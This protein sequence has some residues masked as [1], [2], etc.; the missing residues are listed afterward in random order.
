[1][2]QSISKTPVDIDAASAIA[3][4]AFGADISVVDL[5]ELTEGWFNAAYVLTLDDGQRCVLKVAPPP[6][7]AVLTYERD[8]MTTEVAALGLVRDRTTVPVPLVLW[9][10]T[11]CRRLP[12]SLFVM[13]HCDGML[14]SELRPTL[15]VAQQE[16]VDGQLASYLRKLN[17]I[18]NPT[19]GLQSPLAPKFTRWSDA[20]LQMFDD[21]LAD[22]AAMN[23]EL[24]GG[25]GA[26]RTLAHDHVDVLDEIV[27]PRFVHWDLWDPNV[28]VDPDTLEVI[29]VIDFERAL[30]GDPL[31]EGQFL[32]KVD[33]PSFMEA[34]GVALVETAGARRRRLLYDLYLFVIM[35]VEVA[36]RHYPT[37]E[38]DRLAR[39]QLASTLDKLGPAHH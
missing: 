23:V 20:F 34:Y 9:S 31:M 30:W 6:H 38:I 7:V 32:T 29:G 17:A 15:D 12:S 18:T 8:I 3:R 27:E 13:E 24:P 10:D 22:G 14:L 11:S 39:R 19:F 2:V 16:V 36:Y 21:A 35:A 5:T 4:D 37:D 25:Y 1:V 33:D 26:L 28:F